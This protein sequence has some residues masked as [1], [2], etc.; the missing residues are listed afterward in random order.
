MRQPTLQCQGP[1]EKFRVMHLEAA[2]I[3]RKLQH[4]FRTRINNSNCKFEQDDKD[5]AS[6]E[7]GEGVDC[8]VQHAQP[9]T[10][11]L[12]PAKKPLLL[13]SRN[14]SPAANT[15][16]AA[17]SL[18]PIPERK[19]NHQTSLSSDKLKDFWKPIILAARREREFFTLLDKLKPI[20]L[21][22]T[23]NIE[24]MVD[25]IGKFM[26]Q[27]YTKKQWLAKSQFLTEAKNKADNNNI[28]PVTSR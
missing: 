8:Q 20:I 17:N 3:N 12:L 13:S 1:N 25:V 7:E 16:P 22:K 2:R 23:W 11:I 10:C 24:D 19:T 26:I 14:S 28:V 6:D 15:T 9:E 4:L 5:D 27:A 18:I 21:D